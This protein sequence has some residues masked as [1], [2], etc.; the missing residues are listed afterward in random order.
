MSGGYCLTDSGTFGNIQA[1]QRKLGFHKMLRISSPAELLSASGETP[2]YKGLFIKVTQSHNTPIVEQGVRERIAPTHSWPRHKFGV[3]GQRH[4]PARPGKRTPGT[5]CTGG[6]VGLRA[7]LDTEARRKI[8]SPLPG[9][10]PRSPSRPVRS[11]TLYW[12]SYPG[13]RDCLQLV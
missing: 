7:G 8:L 5:H 2:Y 11:Q 4:A 12:L 10:E 6:W 3:R 9:I 1:T 13:S